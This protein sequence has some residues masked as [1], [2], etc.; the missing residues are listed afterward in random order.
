MS[1]KRTVKRFVALG[2]PLMGNGADY[3]QSHSGD[4]IQNSSGGTGL[5]FSGGQ[6]CR[7]TGGLKAVEFKKTLSR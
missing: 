4:W 2:L 5:S 1:V 6:R 7:K 3:S